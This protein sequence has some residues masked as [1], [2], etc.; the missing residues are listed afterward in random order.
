[1]RGPGRHRVVITGLGA[2]TP[3]GVGAEPLWRAMVAGE[4]AVSL[5][6]RVDLSDLPSRI[7]AEVKDFDPARYLDRKEARRMDRY[8]QFAVVAA[9]GAVQ[10][11]CLDLDRLDRD[12][13][14]VI[15]GTGFGGMETFS[16]EFETLLTKGPARVSPFLV[17][18]MIAN[19]AA[20]W[21]AI[22][23]GARGPN[24]TTVTACA[25]AN[26]A[27]GEAFRL[28]QRGEADVVVT[29]GSEACL[30]RIAYA[31]FCNMRALSTRNDEPARASRP[32]DRG[33]DG[34]VMGEGAGAVVMET[35]E[36]A[37]ARG[38]R[39]YAEVA[40]YGMTADAYHV[41]QPPADGAGGARAMRAALA[42]A[43]LRPEDIDYINAHG[44]STPLGDAGETRAIKAVFGEHA[45]RLAVSSTKSMTGHLLGAAGAVELL[46][47]VKAL[48]TGVIP[49]TINYEEPDPDCDLDYV[50][51]RARP[52]ALRT[53]LS[54][55]FGFGGQNATIIIR[56]F[57]E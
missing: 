49:P 54:N 13:F 5:V 14:G 18:M 6:S 47:C 33:R 40:G 45:R 21:I 55:S 27:A 53:A 12:R 57:E 37:R 36:H 35:L 31:G 11:A 7:G 48:E 51:N 30:S 16:S 10:E 4:S 50:P 41:T 3:Y 43:G 32:F 29:G 19:M 52:A 20:G 46:A 42:D 24:E 44:T 22:V 56:K 1:M 28:L 39:I 25:S 2:V 26:N 23:L 15:W 8:T 38:A 17:P 34:F 9:L